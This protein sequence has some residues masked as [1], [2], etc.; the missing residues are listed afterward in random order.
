MQA[1]VKTAFKF[2]REVRLQTTKSGIRFLDPD[3]RF[4]IA[5]VVVSDYRLLKK[6]SV[7]S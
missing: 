5:H 7:I 3:Y 2:F 1:N 6:W 4:Y